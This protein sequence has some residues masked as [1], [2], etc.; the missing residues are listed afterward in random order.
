MRQ[1]V[2]RILGSAQDGGV[3]QVG[4]RCE[5]CNHAR[6]NA[7]HVRFPA[8]LAIVGKSGRLLL[9]DVTQNLSQQL[10]LI[11]DLLPSGKNLLPAAVLLSHAHV[12]HY[13]GLLF[14]GK[15]V[16]ELQ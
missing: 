1:V 5:R 8:S 12:G 11:R 2:A 15:E 16:A 10:D 13:A 6:M 14:F 7:E 4:C 9:I 3:P